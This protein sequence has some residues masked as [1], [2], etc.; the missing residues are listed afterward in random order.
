MTRDDLLKL[1]NGLQEQVDAMRK[2]GDYDANAA[3][4]R[5]LLEASLVITQHLLDKA[6]K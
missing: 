4:V 3:R 2:L 5:M 1:R 6:R